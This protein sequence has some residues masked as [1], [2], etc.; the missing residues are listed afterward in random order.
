MGLLAAITPDLTAFR[1]SRDYRI[2]ETGAIIASLGTQA[3]LVAV[4]YQVYALTH[5]AALVGLVGAAEL[6][7]M[8]VVNL[9]G[10]ALAD[11]VDRRP[12]LAVAQLGTAV[13]AGT[14]AVLSLTG[15]PPV[16]VI[17]VLAALLAGSGALDSL[18]RS[19][20]I[21]SLAGDWLRSG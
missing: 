13:S 21:V 4:P 9:V 2:I 14:L 19:S 12:L 3:A 18:S 15:S 8:I 10:G 16:W 17:F 5:S 11:R 7:P 1:R 20:M 6:G